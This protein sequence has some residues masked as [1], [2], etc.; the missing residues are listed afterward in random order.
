MDAKDAKQLI[1]QALNQGHLVM[2]IG[3]CN[4]KYEGR[5]ASKLSTGDRMLVIKKD[6]TFLVHQSKGMAAINYQGPGAAILTD[7]DTSGKLIVSAV[8]KKN[9]EVSE[10]II[11]TFDDVNFCHAFDLQDD[12]KITVYG[13][14][15]DLADL[16]MKD[17]HLIELGLIPVQ[18]ESPLAKGH[19]DILARDSKGNLVVIELKRRQAELNAVSQLKRYVEE[20]S[21]RKDCKVRGLLCA[22]DISENAKKMLDNYGFEFY[23]LKYNSSDSNTKIEGLE[24]KQK[25]LSHYFT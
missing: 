4:V 1:N 10:Q 7:I 14:E 2:T 23:K 15:S 18:Q 16:L 11:V 20:V 3:T 21:K 24:K 17:L 25:E 22:P 6:G 5:A 19:I 8:R 13:T 9:G 12:E